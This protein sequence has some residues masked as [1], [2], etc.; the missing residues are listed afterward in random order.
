MGGWGL[1][2]V[3]I[4]FMY[5][6]HTGAKYCIKPQVWHVNMHFQWHMKALK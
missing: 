6:E 4:G 3:V 1:G 5:S 2:V